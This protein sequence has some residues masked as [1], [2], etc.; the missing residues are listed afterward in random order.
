ME[1]R[2]LVAPLEIKEFDDEKGTFKGYGSVFGV[3]DSYGDIVVKGAFNQSISNRNPRSVKLLWQHDASKPI[4]VYEKIYEDDHGL[5]VHGKLLVND[6]TLAK[7][8]YALL[9]SGALDG[10]SIGFKVAKDGLEI[11]K[12]GNTLLKSIDLWEVSLVTFPANQDATVIGI[13]QKISTMN[14]RDLEH[15]LREVAGFS[16][17]E[18][19]ALISQGYAGLHRDVAQSD[20]SEI[21]AK[22]KNLES[23]MRIEH[24]RSSNASSG[25]AHSNIC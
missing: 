25:T 3:V 17:R 21:L 7:E 12:E 1:T 18:A 22:L 11:T 5:V 2:H 9:K 8:A 16:L 6:V 4:G 10:L 19:K 13:K 15:H 20:E 23:I 14:K 24:V